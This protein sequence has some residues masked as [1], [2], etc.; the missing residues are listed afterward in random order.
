MDEEKFK[1]QLQNNF[2]ILE[3]AILYILKFIGDELEKVFSS[4]PEDF[5]MVS[6]CFCNP[7]VFYHCSSNRSSP[8]NNHNLIT[9]YKGVCRVKLFFLKKS[10]FC[11]WSK[12]FIKHKY[13][14]LF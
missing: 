14:L 5:K 12:L 3:V 13:P 9:I 11:C 4:L 2:Y 6:I 8:R 7:F 1:F 10:V